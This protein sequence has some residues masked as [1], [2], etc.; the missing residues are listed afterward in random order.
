MNNTNWLPFQQPLNYILVTGAGSTLP[1]SL[2][3]T[4]TWL[5]VPSTLLLMIP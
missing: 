2:S 1:V 5:K 4:K 3:D